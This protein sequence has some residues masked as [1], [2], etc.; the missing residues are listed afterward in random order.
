VGDKGIA[1]QTGDHQRAIH[2]I[3]QGE[4]TAFVGAIQ[5][6][7]RYRVVVRAREVTL[8]ASQEPTR[9]LPT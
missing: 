5:L 6:T 8:L 9:A 4:E 1:L 3:L 7:E 2:A